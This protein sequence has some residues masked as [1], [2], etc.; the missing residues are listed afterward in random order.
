MKLLEYKIKQL[1]DTLTGAGE[2]GS[3]GGGGGRGKTGPEGRI[4]AAGTEAKLVG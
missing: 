2:G 4:G 3:D 1:I